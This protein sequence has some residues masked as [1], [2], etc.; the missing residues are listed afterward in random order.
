[1]II[2][3]L[4]QGSQQWLEFRLENFMASEAAAMKGD[5][6]YM[7]RNEL[8]DMKKTG[9]S[10]PVSSMQ[11]KLFDKGH[12][13]EKMARPI[14][15]GMLDDGVGDFYPVTGLLE[16]EKIGASFDGLTMMEDVVFEHKLFNKTLAEN[17]RNNVLGPAHYWQLEQQL[18][19]SGAEKVLF[20][21]SDG[22]TENFASMYYE[23]VPERRAGLIAGWKQFA[24]D[25]ANHEVVAKAEK[26]VAN[27]V[28]N[29]PAIQCDVAGSVITTNLQQVL[30]A[31]KD[32]ASFEQS[33]VLESDQDFIDKDAR[34]K[35]YKLARAELKVKR[36]N[37]KN[38]FVSL[39]DFDLVAAE[40]DSVLQKTI[41][42]GEKEI[43]ARKLELKESLK[44]NAQTEWDQRVSAVNG[45]VGFQVITIRPDFDSVMKGKSKVDSLKTA[46][47]TELSQATEKLTEAGKLIDANIAALTAHASSHEFLFNDFAQ[48]VLKPTDDLINLIKM[49]IAEHDQAE[50][51]RKRVEQL[52]MEQAAQEK[53]ER[54]VQARAAAEE[55]RIRSEERAKAQAEQDAIAQQQQAVIARQQAEQAPSIGNHA[56]N[57]EGSAKAT[58]QRLTAQQDSQTSVGKE[59][60][61]IEAESP[62]KQRLST[63]FANTTQSGRSE[64]LRQLKFWKNEYGVRNSEF[65]DLLNI[66]NQHAYLEEQESD[67]A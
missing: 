16:N 36:E 27:E 38:G 51:E 12:A 56:V 31:V 28:D 2:L 42:A 52:R 26:L 17:V 44:A 47:D 21:T 33:I 18:L 46:V 61:P 45:K 32:K 29:L 23:S 59:S 1:M 43:K 8:L 11:Q 22:T 65:T 9:I 48:L 19:V 58:E 60:A 20:I 3:S 53:A 4:K 54:E 55:Q 6:P 66:I 41:S 63:R 50:T 49:R 64:M 24:I 57:N 30:M 5:S 39:A 37:V 67:A 25:L 62:V 15:E 10:K 13:T 40:L 34:I 35:N 7:S 14:A